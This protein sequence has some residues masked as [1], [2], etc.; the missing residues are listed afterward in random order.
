MQILG[1]ITE[2]NFNEISASFINKPDQGKHL[3]NA[4]PVFKILLHKLS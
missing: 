2:I 1:Y 4:K 3:H